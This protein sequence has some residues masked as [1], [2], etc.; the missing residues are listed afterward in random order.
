MADLELSDRQ[1][2]ALGE[3]ALAWVLRYFARASDPPV[4]PTVS[5]A[6]LHALVAEGLPR[7]P[8][9]P[10]RVLEQFERLASLG[11]N[12][13]H[14]RMFGYV[15][16]SGNF[17]G[18]IGDFLASALNQNVTS[19][20]SAPA[21]TTIELQTIEWIKSFVHCESFSGGVLLGGGSAANLAA[22]AA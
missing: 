16:S 8:Q 14:P 9:D 2:R 7:T 10:A 11:R 19:W 1:R 12:N 5:A 20:R 17:A 4:Y 21:A 3:A 18:V 15:Q 13:G 22:L 6:D